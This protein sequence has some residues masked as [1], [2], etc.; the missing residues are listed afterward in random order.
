MPKIWAV[1][2]RM[3]SDNITNPPTLVVN[4]SKTPVLLWAKDLTNLSF[5]W[6]VPS[7]SD[8]ANLYQIT[9]NFSENNVSWY[10][11]DPEEQGNLNDYTYY[12]YAIG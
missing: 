8:T 6:N 9:P 12:Y 4:L 11:S 5:D 1:Y 2:A 3:F 7:G 10:G